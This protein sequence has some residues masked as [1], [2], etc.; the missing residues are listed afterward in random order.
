MLDNTQIVVSVL[1]LGL[2]AGVFWFFFGG[3]RR[4]PPSPDARLARGY[5]GKPQ[6]R[7][8]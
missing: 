1:G 7:E 8:P 6:S 3:K 4:R 5:G 2:M